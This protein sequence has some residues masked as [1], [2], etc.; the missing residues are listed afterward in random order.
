M[1]EIHDVTEPAEL[2]HQPVLDQPPFPVCIELDLRDNSLSASVTEPTDHAMPWD[3]WLGYRRR[4][5]IPLLTADA[6]NRIM[7]EIAPLADRIAADW[8]EGPRMH[9]TD[10]QVVLGKDASAAEGELTEYLRRL[11]EY[12][13]LVD[14]IEVYDVDAA[15][16]GG[17]IIEYG[18][19]PDTTD[20]Q[21]REIADEITLEIADYCTVS[22]V[23]V[24]PGLEEYLAGLRDELCIDDD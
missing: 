19:T 8:T 20:E 21:I 12:P 17:E 7:K 14:L 13:D 23:A 1:V 18:I 24:I 2:F 10:W 3:V 16:N 5:E 9:G 6:A 11:M 15:T 4:Y 22:G